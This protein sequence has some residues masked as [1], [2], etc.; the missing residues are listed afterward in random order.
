VKALVSTTL[1]WCLGAAVVLGGQTRALEAFFSA[2]TAEWIRGD[3]EQAVSAQLTDAAALEALLQ[4]AGRYVTAFEE[5]FSRI[6]GAETY[7][8]EVHS[9]QG[10]A[11]SDLESEVFFVGLDDERAWL[12]VRHVL[13]VNGRSVAGSSDAITE[14]LGGGDKNRRRLRALADASAR[15]NIGNLRRN[16]NDPTLALQFLDPGYQPRFRFTRAGTEVI[17]GT[18]AHRL[19]FEERE[20]PTII[21]DARNGRDVPASGVLFVD[22]EGRVI[23]SELRLRAPRNTTS[24]IRVSYGRDSKLEMLAPQLMEEEYRTFSRSG[25]EVITCRAIYS[26]YRRFETAARILP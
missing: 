5:A 25:P 2:F 14:L 12:T 6:V 16:F 9:P 10:G 4:R 15:H 20:R 8:Q 22:D 3:P 18:P 23:R 7:R 11:M 26:N 13:T 17:D 19:T 21:R 24:S 1:A